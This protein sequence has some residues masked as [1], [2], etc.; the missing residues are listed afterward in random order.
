MKEHKYTFHYK[1]KD[2]EIT[3]SCSYETKNELLDTFGNFL[4]AA[5]FQINDLYDEDEQTL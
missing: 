5:G 3:I 2:E 1:D 4:K